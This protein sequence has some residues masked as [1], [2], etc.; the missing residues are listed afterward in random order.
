M[1]NLN[2]LRKLT[3]RG[4]E[5]IDPA[6][7]YIADD[8]DPERIEPGVKI[9]GGCRIA[10]KLTFIGKGTTLGREGPVTI[11]DCAVGKYVELGGGSFRGSVFLDRSS[12]GPGAQVREACL[13]EEEANGA[14]AVGLKQTILFPFVTLGSLIN[15]CDCLMA[16]GTSRRHHSE[17]GSS[18]VHFNFSPNQDKATPSLIGDVPRGV[19]LDQ[20]PIF[21]GGQGGLVGPT[22]IG[23]GSVVAA[24]IVC[25]ADFGENVLVAGVRQQAKETRYR[26]GVYPEIK[27]RVQNNIHY[28]A[29]LVALRSWYA[30]VRSQLL[31][32]AV[33]QAAI[34][35]L[36]RALA[37]RVSRLKALAEQMPESVK[38]LKGLKIAGIQ[39]V[40]GQERE[41]HAAWP[42]LEELLDGVSEGN[43][44]GGSLEKRGRDEPDPNAA[45]E[46]L[47]DG[48]L[49]RLM[50][51]TVNDYLSFIRA[52]DVETKQKGTE[53]LSS[54]VRTIERAA[55]SFLPS[56]R[57]KS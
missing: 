30:Y 28:I 2:R 50:T 33:F 49:Q 32:P 12:M 39:T 31:D 1:T 17:V 23:F 35:V 10:G 37:E 21:L 18:Y 9:Y 57:G 40:I 42:S 34:A 20:Q 6:S 53:W 43:G 15:F 8:V 36:N 11:E 19:M 48:F 51:I 41:F 26:A 29:N 54:I 56:F 46:T 55:L 22:R 45:D 3:G 52:L 13:L 5:F 25:R 38:G 24:G 7:T 14:H 44:Q 4:V 27:R 16:G 47:R